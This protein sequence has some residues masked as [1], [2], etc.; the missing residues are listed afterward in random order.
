MSCFHLHVVCALQVCSQGLESWSFTGVNTTFKPCEML[1]LSN[2]SFLSGYNSF[3]AFR[4]KFES[5]TTVK[6]SSSFFK[7]TMI[8]WSYKHSF[9]LV[10][11]VRNWKY[12]LFIYS[13]LYKFTNYLLFIMSRN[14]QKQNETQQNWKIE[15][16]MLGLGIEIYFNCK[17]FPE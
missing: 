5:T 15:L 17:V 2:K 8:F 6:I 4:R 16:K 11:Y 9:H 1:I 14:K 12:L 10:R 7:I 3:K 13:W